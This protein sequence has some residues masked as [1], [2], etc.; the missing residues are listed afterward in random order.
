MALL[1]IKLKIVFQFQKRKLSKN[2]KYLA[3]KKRGN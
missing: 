3:K 1:K 2:E